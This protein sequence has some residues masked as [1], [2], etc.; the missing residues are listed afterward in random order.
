MTEWTPE[1]LNANRPPCSNAMD[2]K[3]LAFDAER[4]TVKMEFL[5]PAEWVNP[6]GTI[7]GGFVAA[8]VD[9]VLNLPVL[10]AHSGKAAPLT[11]ELKISY[12]KPMMPGK[13]F[14]EGQIIKMGK[15]IAFLE[16]QL[17]DEQGDVLVK[18][19]STAKLTAV[20]NGQT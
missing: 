4:L 5:A 9:E 15:S 20:P 1:F 14:G 7:Q 3:I 16:A 2:G 12:F 18:A 8:F 13:I 6:R 17:F 10:M 11:L 19:T